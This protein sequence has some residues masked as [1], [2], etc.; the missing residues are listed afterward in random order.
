VRADHTGIGTA[1]GLA[2]VALLLTLLIRADYV[3][4]CWPG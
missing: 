2:A 3:A 4:L 1:A